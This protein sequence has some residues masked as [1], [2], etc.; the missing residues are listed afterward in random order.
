MDV[1]GANIHYREWGRT[2]R[3]LLVLVHGGSAHSG[4][5]DHVAPAFAGKYHVVAP[6]SSGHGDSGW[7]RHYDLDI[8][9]DELVA[10]MAALDSPHPASIVGHSRGGMIAVLA[11][12][13]AKAVPRR[14]VA[15]E[16]AFG[17]KTPMARRSEDG[18]TAAPHRVYPARDEI[19]GRFRTLPS[20][21]ALD[22]VLRHVAEESIRP[23]AGGWTWKFDPAIQGVAPLNTGDLTPSRCPATLIRGGEGLSNE[24]VY[25]E[26]ARR[27][28]AAHVVMPGAGHHIM[29]KQPQE[30]TD[31]LKTAL[32]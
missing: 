10:L 26:S 5:W 17:L 6:D 32:D 4:W 15:A 2:G 29:L 19:L 18:V 28:G 16:A 14:V 21:D 25:A 24:A 1:H 30:F 12:A 3:P 23:V 8:W 31:Q 11:A 27:L 9:A 7:R 20:E 22:F 13:R